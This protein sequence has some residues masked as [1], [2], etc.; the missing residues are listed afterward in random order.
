MQ[1]T[2]MLIDVSMRNT[3]NKTVVVLKTINKRNLVFILICVFCVLVL[4]V[5]MGGVGERA[6]AINNMHDVLIQSRARNLYNF[7]CKG[8]LLTNFMLCF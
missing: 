2:T 3:R 1:T 4:T 7:V 6:E 5:M 8:I